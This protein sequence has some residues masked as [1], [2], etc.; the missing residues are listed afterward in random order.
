M[1]GLNSRA[2]HEGKQADFAHATRAL[3]PQSL[4]WSGRAQASV[5]DD[6][7]EPCEPWMLGFDPGGRAEHKGTARRTAPGPDRA[8]K[9]W[10]DAHLSPLAE[11]DYDLRC[12][13]ILE[14][15]TSKTSQR[16]W[17]QI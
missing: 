16:G 1:R 5:L 12:Q 3:P 10:L 8:A 9:A 14:V 7:L 13:G 15:A 6:T 11:G 17:R 4:L 2:S